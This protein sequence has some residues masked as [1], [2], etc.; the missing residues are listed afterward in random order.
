MSNSPVKFSKCGRIV[1]KANISL[2]ANE[3]DSTGTENPLHCCGF[4][5]AERT[6]ETDEATTIGI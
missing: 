2:G 4:A 5:D 6:L 1:I 3:M